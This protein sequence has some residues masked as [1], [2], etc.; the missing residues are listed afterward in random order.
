MLSTT[1]Q[2]ASERIVRTTIFSAI[3]TTA[4]GRL[5]PNATIYID[6]DA[7]SASRRRLFALLRSAT[8]AQTYL[9]QSL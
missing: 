5:R 7:S 4:Y 2:G 9:Q 1:W 8:S 3:Q 6:A